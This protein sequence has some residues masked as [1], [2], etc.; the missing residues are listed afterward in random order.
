MRDNATDRQ[1]EIFIFLIFI[2]ELQMKDS[3]LYISFG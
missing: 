3:V 2:L 1:F